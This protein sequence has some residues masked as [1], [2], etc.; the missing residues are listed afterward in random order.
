MLEYLI[1]H[2]LFNISLLVVLL[3]LFFI[4]IKI[5][6]NIESY[7]KAFLIYFI[8]SLLLCNL[9]AYELSDYIALDLRIIPFLIGGLYFRLSPILGLLLIAMRG[10][11]G[12]DLGFYVGVIFYAIFSYVIWKLS[13][14]FLKLSEKY[15]ILSSTGITFI[16]SLGILALL[17]IDSTPHRIID[18]WSAYIIVPPLGVAMLAYLI[19]HINKN[20]ILMKELIKSEKFE[21]LEQMGAAISQEIKIP[22]TNSLQYIQNLNNLTLDSND[23]KQHLTNIHD[24]LTSA[25]MV[26]KDYLSFSKPSIQSIEKIDVNEEIIQLIKLMQPLTKQNAIQIHTNLSSKGC[27]NGNRQNFQQC[28]VNIMKNAVEAMPNGGVLTIETTSTLTTITIMI[29]DTGIGISKEQLSRIDEPFYSTKGE[30]GTGVGLMVSYNIVRSMKGTINVRSEL[31]KGTLF[32]L[33]FRK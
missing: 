33:T 12:I 18:V 3:F 11:H 31:G 15:R 24:S 16:V 20:V 21:V 29:E 27:I 32:Q 4:W 14:L 28:L 30:K 25:E 2:F 17:E 5:T 26:I 13:P 1:M 22:I 19:E 6:E 8:L 7:K 10:F 9:F 23:K